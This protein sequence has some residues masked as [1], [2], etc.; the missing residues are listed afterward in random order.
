VEQEDLSFI[1]EMPKVELHL[2]LEGTAK[3][4]GRR[5][6]PR[7]LRGRKREKM[8]REEGENRE[9]EPKEEE[10]EE[11]ATYKGGRERKRKGEKAR[12]KSS[13]GTLEPELMFKMAE[14][15]GIEIPYNSVEEVKEAYK[16]G[17]LGA[18]LEL[19][20]MGTYLIFFLEKESRTFFLQ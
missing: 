9:T 1:T 16:F 13:I 2:H 15:N 5:G 8:G 4:G 18:F 19:Y 12:T 14:R 6:S 7:V 17:S 20:Y 11:R 10:R 3:R